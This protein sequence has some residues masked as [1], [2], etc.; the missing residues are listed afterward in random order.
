MNISN[1][2][3]QYRSTD[4]WTGDT[5]DDSLPVIDP[6]IAIKQDIRVSAHDAF[7]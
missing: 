2:P 4:Y 1:N 3:W 6:V 5:L 7:Q